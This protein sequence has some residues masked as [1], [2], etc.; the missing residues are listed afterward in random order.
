V[1]FQT[2]VGIDL[3]ATLKKSK[4]GFA[5]ARTEGSH[6]RLT[7]AYPLRTTSEILSQLSELEPP[8]LLAI[9]A[10]LKLPLSDIHQETMIDDLETQWD[11]VYT[12]RPWEDLIFNKSSRFKVSGRPF[13]SLA[14][15]YRAQILKGVLERRGWKLI[16]SPNEMTS[17]EQYYFTEVFPNLTMSIMGATSGEKRGRAKQRLAFV[18]GL[19]DEGQHEVALKGREEVD[20]LSEEDEDVLDAIICAW[21]GVL[22]L[23]GKAIVLGDE[24]YGSVACPYTRE[25]EEFLRESSSEGPFSYEVLTPNF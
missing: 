14:I 15:T 20:R 8:V 23:A 19:F 18:E 4:V 10:P 5:I 3:A 7:A 9:D 24:K 11:M 1:H 16:A 21:T 13:S 12:Y 22:F 25:F 2:V 17:N 6:Y